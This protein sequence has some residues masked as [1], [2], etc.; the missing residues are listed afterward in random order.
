MSTEMIQ[1]EQ[2]QQLNICVCVILF[3]IEILL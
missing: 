1:F 2:K 3:V